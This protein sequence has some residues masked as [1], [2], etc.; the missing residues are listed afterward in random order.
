M[1]L[2][3]SI[4]TLILSLAA[5][6]P[7]HAFSLTPSSSAGNVRGYSDST[8]L[9]ISSGSKSRSANTLKSWLNLDYTG[10]TSGSGAL[11]KV[12]PGTYTITWQMYTNRDEDTDFLGLWNGSGS[13]IQ[14]VASSAIA[15][16]EKEYERPEDVD[17]WRTN[18]LSTTFTTTTGQF[19]LFALDGNRRW[20]TT[21]KLEGF[22][23]VNSSAAPEPA[24]FLGIGLATL[25]VSAKQCA[26]SGMMIYKRRRAA[27]GEKP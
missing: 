6:A 3:L 15:N 2:R 4:V 17:R 12:Q 27:G 23:A 25:A 9:Y 7:A 8:D 14:T 10:Y 11:F 20:D 22:E 1:M 16:I 24:T 19:A 18:T 26:G 5:V 21:W 13:T